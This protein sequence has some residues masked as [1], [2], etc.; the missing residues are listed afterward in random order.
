MSA[1]DV[2]VVGRAHK[3]GATAGSAQQ[4]ASESWDESWEWE[5]AFWHNHVGMGTDGPEKTDF[6]MISKPQDQTW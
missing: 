4:H 6:E 2:V 5:R 1:W 3:R